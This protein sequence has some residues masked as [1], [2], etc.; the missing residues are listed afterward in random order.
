MGNTRNYELPYD[1]K[2]YS[3]REDR[4]R[5]TL[6]PTADAQVSPHHPLIRNDLKNSEIRYEVSK[7]SSY[8]HITNLCT[9]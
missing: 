4:L 2:N 3:A 7:K 8:E 1:E 9:T 6:I 5:C